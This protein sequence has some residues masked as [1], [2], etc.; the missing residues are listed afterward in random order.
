MQAAVDLGPFQQFAAV[1]QLL[2]TGGADEMVVDAVDL[3]R[4]GVRVVAETLKCRFG[5]RSR[6]HRTTVD[7]PTAEGPDNTTTR[8][9]PGPRWHWL[10][11]PDRLPYR[12]LG[13]H[14]RASGWAA[15]LAPARGRNT[16]LRPSGLH[17]LRGLG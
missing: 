16:H 13:V 4:R 17:C 10:M 14:S 2:E 15:R 5:I 3:T 9:V 7:L 8:P 11:P 12:P 6:R 1:D